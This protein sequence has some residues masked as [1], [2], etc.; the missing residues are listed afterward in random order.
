M[1][2][3]C[4]SCKEPLDH[5]S[6]DGCAS[7]DKH[8]DKVGYLVI[9]DTVEHEDGS[10]TYTFNLDDRTQKIVAELGLRLTL[11]CAAYGMDIEDALQSIVDRGEYLGQEGTE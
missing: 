3:N 6:G 11:T 8:D 9:S 2:D 5:P 10:A 1:S 7:M 4:A